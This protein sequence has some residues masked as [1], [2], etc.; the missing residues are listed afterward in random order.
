VPVNNVNER[1][2]NLGGDSLLFMDV[3]LSL[4]EHYTFDIMDILQDDSVSGI[5]RVIEQTNK[6]TEKRPEDWL[7]EKPDMKSEAVSVA[8]NKKCFLL[9][10]ATG[11]LGAYLLSDLLKSKENVVCLVRAN[12]VENARQRVYENIKSYGMNVSLNEIN[13]I[14]GDLTQPDFDLS[15][16]D[17][18]Y[19]NENVTDIIHGAAMVNNLSSL[20]LAV[21]SNVYPS[22]VLLEMASTGIKKKIH[23]VSTLS[24]FV[25]STETPE[26]IHEGMSCS[27]VDFNALYTAYA[28]SKWLNEF[29]LET[30]KEDI[31]VTHYRLG[32]LTPA[33][34]FPFFKEK[35]Y[36]KE[37]FE[38]LSKNPVVNK[39]ALRLSFDLTPVDLASS[40]MVK[41]M[42]EKRIEKKIVHITS[43]EKVFLQDLKS[44]LNLKVNNEDV[45]T[46]LSKFSYEITGK[47]SAMNIFETTRV[48]TFSPSVIINI[49]KEQYLREYKRGINNV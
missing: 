42:K 12:N 37:V 34:S 40:S 24:V 48:K 49:N 46:S 21:K 25:S 31:D 47:N 2:Y 19:L 14:L 36:L 5:A 15:P 41:L 1:F 27:T 44:I 39:N 22:K 18:N 17:L 35:Q 32:L 26:V 3:I 16:D 13:V 8:S 10:G 45:S 28:K 43:D 6:V 11:F 29:Y 9:T 30:Y 20:D 7:P 4:E 33:L 23:N 38:I